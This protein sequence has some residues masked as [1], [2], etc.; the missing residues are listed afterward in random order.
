MYA[1]FKTKTPWNCVY[2]RKRKKYEEIQ[3][4]FFNAVQK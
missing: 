4:F 3:H 2:K 1:I